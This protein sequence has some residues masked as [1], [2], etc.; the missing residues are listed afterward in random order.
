[1]NTTAISAPLPAKAT[2]FSLSKVEAIPWYLW[3]AVLATA[4]TSSGLYWDISWHMTIGRDTFWT[5][6]HLLIQFGAV[7][8]GLSCAYLIF[9]TTLSRD[10]EARESSVKVMGLHG[11]L[12]AFICAWGAGTMVLSAPFDNWWHNAYGLDV[13]IISPP[14]QMLGIGIEGIALGGAILIVGQMNRAQG[15][16]RTRLAWLLLSLGGL[17]MTHSMMGRLEYTDRSLMHSAVMYLALAI[18][19]PFV[20]EAFARP[21]GLRWGRTLITA[22]YTAYFLL[23]EWIFPL[24]G[25]EPKLGPVYQRVT[26]MVPLGFPILIL[27]SAVALDFLWPKLQ[28]PQSWSPW[29]R[30]PVAGVAAVIAF[31][32]H[33]VNFLVTKQR[34]ESWNRWLQATVAGVVFVLALV[35]IQWP[36]GNFLMSSAA[37]NWIFGTQYHPYMA[38]AEW[39]S[40]RNMFWQFETT[41]AQFWRNMAWAFFAAIYG[42]RLA[43]VFGNW[44]RKVQR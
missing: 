25:G 13:K 38:S 34:Q 29:L 23:G 28:E 43:I 5:P 7:L 32:F 26:H 9:A 30:A 36:F 22:V 27:A 14:H 11:P 8:A 1:M 3:S 41:S 15:I 35:A 37:R 33:I 24:F 44:M 12:G 2:E 16:L 40:V 39:G 21:S 17:M 20:M 4:C 42:I 10:P 19:P 31:P 18:G 6:A